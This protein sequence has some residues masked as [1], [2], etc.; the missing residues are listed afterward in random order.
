M[1]EFY[2]DECVK[3]KIAVSNPVNNLTCSR[4][5]YNMAVANSLSCRLWHWGF[6]YWSFT[7][8]HQVL[9]MPKYFGTCFLMCSLN[10]QPLF[11]RNVR[12]TYINS[13]DCFNGF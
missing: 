3:T 7:H 10:H 6:W 4:S 9:N 11:L 8:S 1:V 13:G 2:R 12:F 5:F